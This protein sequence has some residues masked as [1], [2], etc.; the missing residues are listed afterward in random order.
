MD[1]Y[2]LTEDL[3]IK[4]FDSKP[5]I[6]HLLNAAQEYSSAGK[7][8]FYPSGRFTRLILRMLRKDKPT[9]FERIYGCFDKSDEANT[10]N[11]ISVYPLHQLNEHLENISMLFVASNNFYAK[12]LA[13]LASFKLPSEKLYLTSFYDH[14]YPKDI[15]STQFIRLFKKVYE[16]LADSESKT[17][18][19]LIWLSRILNDQKATAV[20]SRS[21]AEEEFRN[22]KTFKGYTLEGIEPTCLR[23][24][25][26]DIYYME[27]V[28]PQSGDTVFDVGAYRGDT[29]ISFAHQVKPDGRVY[30]FE[31]LISN[32]N[33]LLKNIN[34]NKLT[35]IIQ[36]F[37]IGFGKE[38]GKY[39]MIT[40]N[41]GAPWSYFT[42]EKNA[43]EVIVTSLDDFV[44]SNEIN[45]LDYIKFDVEG[46]EKACL[47]GGENTFQRLKP[48]MVIPMYHR[49]S[50]L[51]ELPL[52][53]KKLGGYELYIR[54]KIDGAYGANLYCAPKPE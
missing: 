36:P 14:S 50:D 17:S 4:H 40:S 19:L 15:S 39:R 24:L 12:E 41:S 23:E 21:E 52:L 37:N 8:A 47:M 53:L 31:P 5:N 25:F 35:H 49:T 9:I 29:A 43:N 11:G 7:I 16:S 13:D 6:E 38:S 48:Q 1:L 34:K 42:D 18:Y 10:V 45:K 22:S 3:L 32:Y 28:T 54:C 30:S 27:H 51:I 46:M 26:H 2:N 33:W 44:S 20:F